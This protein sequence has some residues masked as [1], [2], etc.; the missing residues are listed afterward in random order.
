MEIKVGRYVLRSDEYCMWVDEEYSDGARKRRRRVAGYAPNA[1]ALF[2]QFIRRRH[3]A[4]GAS[5]MT[6][7]LDAMRQAAEDAEA[8]RKAALENDFR[9]MR[10]A[11]AGGKKERSKGK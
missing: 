5:D 2:R 1:E 10:K 11:A 8:M 7:L 4:E 3:M 9:R 6:E